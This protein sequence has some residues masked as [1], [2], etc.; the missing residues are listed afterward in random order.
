VFSPPWLLLPILGRSC[1]R[2]GSVPQPVALIPL[3]HATAW[4]PCPLVASARGRSTLPNTVHEF[5]NAG[6]RQIVPSAGTTSCFPAQANP[7]QK[8]GNVA[9]TLMNVGS[10]A[11]SSA[12][13]RGLCVPVNGTSVAESFRPRPCLRYFAASVR[14]ARSARPWRCN[15]LPPQDL[16]SS[17][18]AAPA[19]G[20]A[21]AGAATGAEGV[22]A[23]PYISCR[24]S[25]TGSG[26]ASAS[27][28]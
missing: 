14:R 10:F 18:P 24:V 23:S 15:S 4:R 6:V 12:S 1:A 5:G 8:P 17:W 27:R 28:M 7:F 26:S 3:P 22:S 2:G 19:A 21:G 20:A 13:A 11:G 9:Q 16:S 25:S